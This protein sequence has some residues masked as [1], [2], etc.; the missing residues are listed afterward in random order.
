MILDPIL[1]HW[2]AKGKPEE[3]PSGTWGPQSADKM[4]ARDGRV[5]RRP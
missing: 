2:A 3:Y 5:W 1:E 4:L